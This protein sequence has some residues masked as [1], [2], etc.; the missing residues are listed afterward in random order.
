MSKLP[1]KT[2]DFLAER[3]VKK[4]LPRMIG[5]HLPVGGLEAAS[6][7]ELKRLLSEISAS[8]TG[9]R[10]VSLYHLEDGS[11]VLKLRSER[12]SGEL[13]IVPG[14]FFYLVEGSY[15]KPLK[16]SQVGRTL[17]SLVEGSRVR[18]ISLVEG[19]RI[20]VLELEKKNPIRLV[21]ELLPK[22]TVIALDERGTILACL[23]RLEMRDRR[24]APG[25]AYKLPPPKPAPTIEN[26]E[27]ALRKL[28]PRRSI[29]SA[30]ASEA[31]LGGRYAEE[32]LHLA[33]IDF[34]EKVRDLDESDLRKIL[35]SA[36]KVFELVER[37]QPTIAY[38]PDGSA[39]ALPY[40]MSIFKS[41]GWVMKEAESLNEAYRIA[42]EHNLA[43]ALEEERMKAVTEKIRE[44]R[45]RAE[46]RRRS[47]Q[48]ILSEASRMREAAERLFQLA[49]ELESLKNKP[50]AHELHGLKVVVDD[51]RR[52][53]IIG[54]DDKKVEFGLEKSLMK[55][56]SKMFDDAKKSANAARRLAREAEELERE[57]EKL[58]REAQESLEKA[59]L[60]VS[61]R[62]KPS[63]GKWYERY[64]WFISSEGFLAVAG[65]D[66][67]SNI[68]LL[69]KH[70]EPNDLVFHAE[71]RGAAVVI[72]K[73]GKSSGEESRREAAQF[74]AAYS[75]AW[76]EG[77]SMITVYYV[78]PSQISFEPPPGHYLPKGGFIVKG[79]RRYLQAKLELAIGVT[80]D[81]SLIYGP[82][83]AIA[84]RALSFVR[85]EPGKVRA[86]ELAEEI[87][88]RIFR[89]FDLDPKR[90]RDLRELIMEL[91]PYGRARLVERD[92][93]FKVG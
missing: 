27:D 92:L 69:K 36:R 15:E 37:G 26:L 55:Q 1:L 31:G 75:R 73:N 20:L 51:K 16:L 60:K 45:K 23:H 9:A 24:I 28:S 11:I 89:G 53:L 64:R 86:E 29:V 74:A 38:S 93:N 3:L 56:I 17:R 87:A 22:G 2:S 63:G 4:Y 76:R 46:E 70:L 84:R 59:L 14:K 90:L 35:E 47:A 77:L 21:C 19:E 83:T 61:A 12:F 52:R 85:L 65:K 81:L 79:E 10:V 30:L 8:V 34:S 7:L 5:G 40:P 18:S 82:P 43:R 67:S 32:I 6:Y 78:E 66:A 58:E 33:G 41:R 72:L 68:A 54:S 71:V 49:A 13:R 80:E 42:Y 44:L 50:G 88:G 62:I 25:E 48:R 91:I 39:Q 57:A